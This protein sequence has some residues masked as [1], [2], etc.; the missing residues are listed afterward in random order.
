MA[1]TSDTS[2]LDEALGYIYYYNNVREH[3]ALANLTPFEYLKRQA[4]DIDEAIRYVQPILLDTASVS[5]GPWSGYN[6]LT[7]NPWASI[8]HACTVGLRTNPGRPLS[9]YVRPTS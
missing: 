6:V 5:L 8:R 9:S 1:I 2:L 3:S 4:P 7:Q